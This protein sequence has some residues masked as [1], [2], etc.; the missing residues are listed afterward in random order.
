MEFFE[1]SLVDI[2]ALRLPINVLKPKTLVSDCSISSIFPSLQPIFLDRFF[3]ITIS[4][5]SAPF[6]RDN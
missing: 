6:E 3:A 4:E 1:K 5:E 2:I